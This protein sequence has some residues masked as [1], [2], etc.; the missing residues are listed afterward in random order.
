MK[1]QVFATDVTENGSGGSACRS[2]FVSS[3]VVTDSAQWAHPLEPEFWPAGLG[4]R[5]D[6]L[7][8]AKRLDFVVITGLR[9]SRDSKHNDSANGLACWF[10]ARWV[11]FRKDSLKSK[12]LFTPRIP[13]QYPK[14]AIYQRLNDTVDASEIRGENQLRLVVYQSH[15]LRRGFEKSQVVVQDFWTINS[16]IVMHT[17]KK[18]FGLSY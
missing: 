13:N 3:I 10:G 5:L 8:H 6:S 9:G 11:G 2:E 4:K 16:T 1:N 7:G 17:N 12:G 18:D 14:S 15:Y